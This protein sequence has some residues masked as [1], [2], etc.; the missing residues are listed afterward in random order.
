[1]VEGGKRILTTHSDTHIQN[2]VIDM[3]PKK[4]FVTVWSNCRVPA[5]GTVTATGQLR[6]A[7]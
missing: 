5:R 4:Q 3:S 7:E 1:M 2:R 6:G